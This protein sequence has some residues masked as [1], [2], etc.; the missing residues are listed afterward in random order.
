MMKRFCLL[1]AFVNEDIKIFLKTR[2]VL[3]IFYLEKKELS[4]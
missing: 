4:S 3:D 1:G 2:Y